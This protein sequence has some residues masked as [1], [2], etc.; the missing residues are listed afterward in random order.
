[1]TLGQRA[2]ESGEVSR[3]HA[4]GWRC[5]EMNHSDTGAKTCI[6]DHKW[7]CPSDRSR[8]HHPLKQEEMKVDTDK[9]RIPKLRASD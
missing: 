7:E 8:E 3:R 5:Y 6:A 4:E 1:M 2:E 9:A